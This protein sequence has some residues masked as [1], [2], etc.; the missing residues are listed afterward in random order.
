M[1]GSH[2]R[3]SSTYLLPPPLLLHKALFTLNA[4]QLR[5]TALHEEVSFINRI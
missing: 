2:L 1:K 5:H 4:L 3:S